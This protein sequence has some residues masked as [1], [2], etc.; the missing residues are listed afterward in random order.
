MRVLVTMLLTL[1]LTRHAE[2]D[3][4]D[5]VVLHWKGP[6]SCRDQGEVSAEAR[7]MLP[8]DGVYEPTR[9]EIVVR[10]QAGGRRYRLQY[11]ARSAS[12]VADREL[13]LASCEEAR[14]AGALLAAL[15]LD[16]EAV[17]LIGEPSPP[18]EVAQPTTSTP[19]AEGEQPEGPEPIV[20]LEPVSPAGPEAPREFPER[21]GASPFALG[22]EV[23][24]AVL[25]DTASL[26]GVGFG[27][28]IAFGLRASGLRLSL[29]ALYLPGAER[30]H[31]ARAQ[32]RVR[33]TLWTGQ[34]ALCQLWS[35]ASFEL[36][37]CLS[38]ELG[39]YAA[40]SEGVSHPADDAVLWAAGGVGLAGTVSLGERLSLLAALSL[41]APF[42][43]PVL[44][45]R[46]LGPAYT[47]PALSLRAALGVRWEIAR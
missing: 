6:E 16:P 13:L 40:H 24:V 19:P 9:I 18:A 27:P 35:A 2:A 5:G 8:A 37:P 31:E 7:R 32:A 46:D 43:R 22:A 36:G 26:P 1:G 42:R 30:G 25:S 12:R 3:P 10:E 44:E 21:R 39:R 33:A 20:G 11:S 15:T 28:F 45:L 23:A 29:A 4:L 34:L 41:L 17:A 38:G 47:V 14:Q